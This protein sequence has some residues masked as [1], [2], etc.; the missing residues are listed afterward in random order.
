MSCPAHPTPRTS[1]HSS[2]D[3]RAYPPPNLMKLP[4][5]QVLILAAGAG[6]RLRGD[7]TTSLKPLQRVAGR[8]LI[9]HV[10]G[11]FHEVGVRKFHIVVGSGKDEITAHLRIAAA[12]RWD[13][14]FIDNPN[15]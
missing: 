5:D 10:I 11:A 3:P 8:A 13:L 6:S 12:G 4:A 14:Y 1:F 15:W 7:G 2:F 9:E